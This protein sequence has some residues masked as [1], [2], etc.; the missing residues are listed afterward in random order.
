MA[1]LG[2][3]VTRSPVLVEDLVMGSD[4]GIWYPTPVDWGVGGEVHGGGGGS[5]EPEAPI[6]GQLYPSGVTARR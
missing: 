1:A 4:W 2:T 3:G 6:W 5:V